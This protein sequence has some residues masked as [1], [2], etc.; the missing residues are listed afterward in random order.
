[1][2]TEM[3]SA[4]TDQNNMPRRSGGASVALGLL[5]LASILCGSIGYTL[6]ELGRSDVGAEPAVAS[7]TASTPDDLLGLTL[8]TESG[9]ATPDLTSRLTTTSEAPSSAQDV[10]TQDRAEPQPAIPVQTSAL[11]ALDLTAGEAV[12]TALVTE[13]L[14]AIYANP[15]DAS[16]AWDLAV[17]TEFG[18]LRHFL[19]IGE[20]GDWLEVQVPVR[21]N[22]STGWI[23]RSA[24]RLAAVDHSV[25]IDISERS[26][27][28]WNGD[29][30]VLDTTGAVGRASAPTPEGSFYIRDIFEWNPESV[31]GPFVLALSSYSETID[32]INGGDAV[33]AIHGTNAPWDLG[34]AV[35][36]GCIRL[37]NEAVTLLAQTVG[38]GTP[39]HIVP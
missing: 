17:P 23:H 8:A 21:P 5:C 12:A 25:Q 11:A 13:G 20:A 7:A 3:E 19:V 16:A 18:G 28:V 14:V 27:V 35:S 15:D 24:V 4:A 29:E 38:P 26:V 32:Q 36:L 31:Y 9:A 10:T 34:E 1:M 2:G 37:D 22:G 33:V 6:G 39:V 30:V